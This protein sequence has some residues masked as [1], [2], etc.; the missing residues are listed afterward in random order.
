M[1]NRVIGYAAQ[2]NSLC[3]TLACFKSIVCLLAVTK[4]AQATIRKPLLEVLFLE[5]PLILFCLGLLCIQII[6]LAFQLGACFL[7]VKKI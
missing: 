4:P 2:A 5:S 3:R 7:A 1:P 6:Y